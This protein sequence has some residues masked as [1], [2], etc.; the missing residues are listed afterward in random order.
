GTLQVA[1]PRSLVVNATNDEAADTD[2]KTS[3]REAILAANANANAADVITFDP[4]VFATPQVITMNGTPLT[5]TDPVTITGPGA[6]NVTVDAALGSRIMPISMPAAQWGSL[7]SLSGMT[8]ANG[9]TLLIPGS[10][11]ASGAGIAD[12][13]AAL[14]V[15]SCTITGCNLTVAS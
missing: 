2:G 5:I 10:G 3:L 4:T 13:S 7:V 6:A 15:D 11:Q 14:T 1:I 9:Q 12:D 8:L